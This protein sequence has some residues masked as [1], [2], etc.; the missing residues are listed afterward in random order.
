MFK[1]SL[2]V[3]LVSMSG[4]TAAIAT[5]QIYLLQPSYFTG[6]VQ[7]LDTCFVSIENIFENEIEARFSKM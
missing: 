2:Q 6:F 5:C 1:T 3:F 4:N 7:V